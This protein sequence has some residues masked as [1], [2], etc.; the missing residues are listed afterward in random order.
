M[1]FSD[2]PYE[3]LIE[4]IRFYFQHIELSLSFRL[5]SLTVP[6]HQT[7]VVTSMFLSHVWQYLKDKEPKNLKFIMVRRK[8]WLKNFFIFNFTFYLVL[9][10]HEYFKITLLSFISKCFLKGK[11]CLIIYSYFI[12]FILFKINPFLLP[13]I[14]ISVSVRTL[15]TCQASKEFK[16]LTGWQK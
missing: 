14:L 2:Y 5:A 16:G 10:G 7:S 9:Y 6:L 1:S 8:K 4:W 12:F 13:N 3:Y 15:V 11:I